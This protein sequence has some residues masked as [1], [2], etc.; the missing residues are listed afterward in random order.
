MALDRLR[1][2]A[3]PD[4]PTKSVSLSICS[5]RAF[6]PTGKVFYFRYRSPSTGSQP[7]MRLGTYPSFSLKDA[8][9]LA[10]DFLR[11]IAK[12]E[13]PALERER[14][15]AGEDTFSELS[16]DYLEHAKNHKKNKPS[17]LAEAVRQL[18]QYILP[19]W[20]SRPA[21]GITPRD[22]DRVLKPIKERGAMV[23]A[24][25]TYA[26]L[27]AVFNFA[28]RSTK[29]QS[30]V[31]ENPV[32]RTIKPLAKEKSREKELSANE[33]R[34]LWIALDGFDP[35]VAA[36][37]KLRLLTAQRGGEVRHMRWSE[38]DGDW[39]TIPGAKTKNDRQHRVYLSRATQEVLSA[40]EPHRRDDWVLPS[41]RA[42][43]KPVGTLA[44][45]NERLRSASELGDFRPHDLRR[46][47][48][49]IMA[50]I[51]IEPH[52]IGRVLNHKDRSITDRYNRFDYKP[53]IKDALERWS[54][55][56]E[57]IVS[58]EEI[59]EIVPIRSA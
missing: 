53:Q 28:T 27:S 26:L 4:P 38:I 54:E 23:Q 3:L 44:K 57:A 17:S 2:Q 15:K 41:P 8:R 43:G 22:V 19:Q 13:D 40:V 47:A 50:E 48:A 5:E 45:A 49:T 25:R 14:V 10:G 16:T 39:W 11:Q 42:D 37:F 34:R 36:T 20:K 55:R 12:G 1:E 31:V 18:N 56:L 33:L 35:I 30:L 6:A 7:R 51:G 29:W 52:I 58:N 21:G 46:T 9:Q 24:N 59:A 32:K